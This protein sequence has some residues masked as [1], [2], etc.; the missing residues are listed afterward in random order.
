MDWGLSSSFHPTSNYE[1]LVSLGLSNI[2]S[3][4]LY[5]APEKQGLPKTPKLEKHSDKSR[6][7]CEDAGVLLPLRHLKRSVSQFKELHFNFNINP[8]GE[9]EVHERINGF[10]GGFD[11]VD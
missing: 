7:S 11:D 4:V 5:H 10:V 2:G 8:C 3:I 6:D 1:S 9:F